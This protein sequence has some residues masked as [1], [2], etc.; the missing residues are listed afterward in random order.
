MLTPEQEAQVE[1]WGNKWLNIGLSTEQSSDEDYAE[2]FKVVQQ[3]YL[4]SGET[5]IP[6]DYKVVDSPMGIY[7]ICKNK[8]FMSDSCYGSFEA[9]W[10]SY[11]TFARDVLGVELDK[12]L[13]HFVFLSNHVSVY[14][15]HEETKT[16]LFSKKPTEIHM[17][18]D[19]LHNEKGPAIK[20]LDGFSIWAINGHHVS[21]QIVMRPE[22]LT[23]EQINDET[24]ADIQSI[25]LERFGWERY[26]LESN[27]KLIDGRKN[28]IEN[29]MEALYET[30]RFGRRIVFTCPTGRVFVKGVQST[31]QTLTC[32]GA[33]DWLA[34]NRP[35]RTIGR[36]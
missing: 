28:D 6:L 5:D 24:N 13:E 8:S 1:D 2:C 30:E 23:V 32:Q 35:W 25:M 3:L 18:G 15:L 17:Q 20:F 19:V 10:L 9:S 16:V 4:D 14:Y 31:P 11:Y 33:Q 21:E 36:T 22:T 29:T 26:I 7:E 12:R 27:A 34:G